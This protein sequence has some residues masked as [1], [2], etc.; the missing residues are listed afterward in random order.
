MHRAIVL[1]VWLTACR[2]PAVDSA[3]SNGAK[4]TAYQ[5]VAAG[6]RRPIRWTKNEQARELAIRTLRNTGQSSHHVVRLNGAEKPHVHDYHDLTVFVLSGKVNM[7]LGEHVSS[8]ETGDVIDIPAG[9]AHWAENAQRA[10][11]EAYV[12]FVP[13]FDGKDRRPLKP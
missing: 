2:T 5:I 11:S 12:V 3:G 4:R 1:L 6:Q 13:G 9:Q 8:V 7:H 10:A